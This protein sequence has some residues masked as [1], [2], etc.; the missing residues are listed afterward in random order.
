MIIDVKAVAQFFTRLEERRP[1]LVD[2]DGLAGARIASGARRA[3]LDGKRPEPSKFDPFPA[4]QRIGDFLEDNGNDPLN[5]AMKQVRIF[6]RQLF[7]QFG[8]YH[9]F[10]AP[11][12]CE[13]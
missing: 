8:F 11:L 1:F 6:I 3:M 9:C 7:N 13:P 12:A 4:R 10:P 2:P 5:I